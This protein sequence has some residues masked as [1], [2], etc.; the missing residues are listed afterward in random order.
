MKQPTK[1]LLESL[2]QNMA[3]KSQSYENTDRKSSV[4]Y[5]SIKSNLYKGTP[6]DKC[7]Y[8]LEQQ[9]EEALR[10]YEALKKL[11]ADLKLVRGDEPSAEAS[12]QKKKR[13][14]DRRKSDAYKKQSSNTFKKQ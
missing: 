11:L 9:V 6:L 13:S 4:I 3:R 12:S 5:S 10:H 8:G 14:K 7:I 1:P 2:F